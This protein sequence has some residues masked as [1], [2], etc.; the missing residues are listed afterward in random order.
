MQ[1][2]HT[3][4]KRFSLH[5]YWTWSS[6]DILDKAQA[7]SFFLSPSC[8][9]KQLFCPYFNLLTWLSLVFLIALDNTKISEVALSN[10]NSK[11]QHEDFHRTWCKQFYFTGRY[12]VS[13]CCWHF[14]CQSNLQGVYLYSHFKLCL[15]IFEAVALF[16]LKVG[17]RNG[18]P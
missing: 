15:I 8:F 11:K 14:R 5:Q 9:T 2:T 4:L 10:I 16:K 6:F 3:D 13:K 7:H 17:V 1:K 18:K 12:T